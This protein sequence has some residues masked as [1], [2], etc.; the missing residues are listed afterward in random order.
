MKY[1]TMLVLGLVAVACG[2]AEEEPQHHAEDADTPRPQAEMRAAVGDHDASPAGS[3]IAVEGLVR[4]VGNDPSPQ[5]VL[6]VGEGTATTQ[7]ALV[8]TFRDELGRLSGV[9]VAVVG[10]SIANPQGMP[11]HAIDVLEYDIVAV[12]SAPAYLGVLAQRDGVWWLDREDSFR[13]TLMPSD[14]EGRAGAKVWIAGPVDGDELRVQSYGVV[15]E[16]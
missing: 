2:G 9:A 5:V 3:N 1:S 15:N 8:G 14:L 4:V 13:L 6:S 10:D 7:I 11:A 16:P 12:N